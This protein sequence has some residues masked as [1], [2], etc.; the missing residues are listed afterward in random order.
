MN[1]S[2][3]NLDSPA[4]GHD[5]SAAMGD[6]GLDSD[7]SS[8]CDFSVMDSPPV[9]VSTTMSYANGNCPSTL[10]KK[11]A[12]LT[13]AASQELDQEHESREN[14]SRDE[15]RDNELRN[16][17]HHEGI[18]A[19]PA[20]SFDLREAAAGGDG[21]AD[22]CERSAIFEE[23]L[24][25]ASEDRFLG[26]CIGTTKMAASGKPK[27]RGG[28]KK[29]LSAVE[30]EAMEMAAAFVVEQEGIRAAETVAT[31]TKDAV[32]ARDS[33]RVGCNNVSVDRG[34][35]TAAAV[36]RTNS[37][38]RGYTAATNASRR[39]GGLPW[40]SLKSATVAAN[41]PVVAR[42]QPVS[43]GI[44]APEPEVAPETADGKLRLYETGEVV[45]PRGKGGG[46]RVTC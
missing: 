36:S 9:N 11:M 31:G 5:D 19:V 33:S 17:D 3:K 12:G 4:A 1:N 42:R 8:F 20:S 34:S 10:V 24:H 41:G 2:K 13:L 26:G 23:M 29:V 40:N 21:D 27:G 46:E 22:D 7:M 45:K 25:D 39:G 28:G 14:E 18:D 35:S 30:K 15:S 43:V 16:D 38:R 32:N 6:V 44:G 37:A